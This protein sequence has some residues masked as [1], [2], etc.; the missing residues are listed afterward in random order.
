MPNLPI[1]TGHVFIG[2]AV[3]M[4]VATV[5]IFNNGKHDNRKAQAKIETMDV[6]VPLTPIN[7]GTTLSR[8]DVTLVKWPAAFLPKGT[9]FSDPYKVV[10]RIA[11]Q[12]LYPG[13]PIFAQK[14]SGTNTKGGLT[15]IIPDGMRAITIPVTEVKGVAGFVKPGDHVDVL[16]TFE[17]PKQDGGDAGKRTKTVLQDVLVLASAQNMVD[18]NQIN[19]ETP[20]GVIRGE[21]TPESA[22]D[23]K[24]DKDDKSKDKKPSPQ[25]L[26]KQAKEREKQKKEAEKAA[27]LVSSV[28]LALSP[29][30]AETMALAEETGDLHLV[31]RPEADHSIAKLNGQDSDKLLGQSSI[32]H[33]APHQDAAPPSPPKTPAPMPT[34][35]MGAEVEFIQGG[36][37]TLY[38]FNQ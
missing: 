13:E 36:D 17:I 31:L 26:E 8:N 12:N 18:N 16:T 14:I 32:P 11:K 20:D 5:G 23:K 29:E 21:A 2:L 35:Y 22:E 34:P 24:K 27:K 7:E 28:T 6:V 38:N 15:A 10:G 19:M 25:D 37:K 9:T 30:Q 1:K 33:E 3:I 4:G